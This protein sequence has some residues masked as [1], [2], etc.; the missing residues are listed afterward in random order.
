MGQKAPDTV[1]KLTHTINA[2]LFMENNLVTYYKCLFEGGAPLY[3]FQCRVKESCCTLKTWFIRSI[4]TAGVH[5]SHQPSMVS[6]LSPWLA[7]HRYWE[8]EAG[9]LDL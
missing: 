8:A 4:Q 5:S 3:S 2:T 9:K 7:H 6:L 1:K